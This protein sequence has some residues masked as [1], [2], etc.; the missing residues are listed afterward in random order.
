MSKQPVGVANIGIQMSNWQIIPRN[1]SWF[2]D[3]KSHAIDNC[4]Q[5]MKIFMENDAAESGF[6]PASHH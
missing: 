1:W 4:T 5:K 2:M 6:V 3:A